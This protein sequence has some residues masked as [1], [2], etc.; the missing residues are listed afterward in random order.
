MNDYQDR[1]ASLN[2][3]IK[4]FQ[5]KL[6]DLREEM[7]Y[8]SGVI[9]EGR[10]K[11]QAAKEIEGLR[12]NMS[13]G[14]AEE[15]GRK[16]REVDQLRMLLNTLQDEKF[17]LDNENNYFAGKIGQLRDDNQS[18]RA[19]EDTL[20]RKTVLLEREISSIKD[21]QA[22]KEKSRSSTLNDNDY[23]SS[24]LDKISSELL[25]AKAKND[26]LLQRINDCR[27]KI[28]KDRENINFE[29]K[30][31]DDLLRINEKLNDNVTQRR[32]EINTIELR[33]KGLRGDIDQNIQMANNFQKDG[34][35]LVKKLQYLYDQ[36]YGIN[37]TNTE[38]TLRII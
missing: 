19:E 13:K 31:C 27:E 30:L 24:I 37:T 11:L 33:I 23:Q 9:R 10:A 26:D 36:L 34:D 29:R 2:L 20:K 38:V 6:R 8:R 15:V 18:L 7:D 22:L 12:D 14:L 35:T 3:R 32:Q 17:D 25:Q 16:V 5:R 21:K 4:A 1:E 28:T